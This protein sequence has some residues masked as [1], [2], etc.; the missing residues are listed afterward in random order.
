M[1]TV[2]LVGPASAHLGQS[3][4]KLGQVRVVTAGRGEDLVHLCLEHRPGLLLLEASSQALEIIRRMMGEY[5]LPVVLL[6]A[7]PERFEAEA[8]RAGA[9]SITAPPRTE[10]EIA[11]LARHL[12]SMSEVPV[13]RRRKPAQQRLGMRVWTVGLVA[14]LGGPQAL[15]EVMSH[16]EGSQAVFLAVQH[17]TPDSM[18]GFADWLGTRCPLPVQLAVHGEDVQGGRLYLARPGSHLEFD[19]ERTL[20]VQSGP[21]SF[22]RPSGTV[23]LSSL[24]RNLGPAAVGIVLTGLGDDGARGLLELRAA[25]GYTLVES[26][27]SAPTFGMPAAALRMNAAQEACPLEALGPRIKHMVANVQP[28]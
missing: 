3:L 14:S 23:L 20:Q 16:M 13:I 28:L 4:Q 10:R 9:L 17:M 1:L 11:D 25:G 7:E 8:L 18:L 19:G 12:E 27:C 22:Q 24:A 6:A 2:L 15:A 21:V 26:Q 5:P